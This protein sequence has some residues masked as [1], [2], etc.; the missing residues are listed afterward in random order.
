ML[1]WSKAVKTLY[2]LA[3][4]QL[5]LSK[6]ICTDLADNCCKNLMT[7]GGFTLPVTPLAE[8]WTARS[9]L[10]LCTELQLLL[11]MAWT[12]VMRIMHLRQMSGVFCM[13]SKIAPADNGPSPESQSQLAAHSCETT[14][15]RCA[16]TDLKRQVILQWIGATD[17]IRQA[18]ATH[19]YSTAVLSCIF[20]FDNEVRE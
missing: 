17:L 5:M 12:P 8:L 2:R 4:P 20:S 15:N 11:S 16:P 3:Q 6:H 14:Q 9:R 18:R 19:N 7:Q 13:H 10:Q 1:T